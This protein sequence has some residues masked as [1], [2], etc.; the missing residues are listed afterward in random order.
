MDLNTVAVLGDSL[1]TSYRDWMA[2]GS[3]RWLSTSEAARRL[4]IR[5][6]SLQVQFFGQRGATTTWWRS[7]AKS[8]YFRSRFKKV[9][10]CVVIL[11]TNDLVAGRSALQAAAGVIELADLLHKE[12]GVQRVVVL[13]VLPRTEKLGTETVSSFE[14]K[15]LETNRLL[16]EMCDV[17]PYLSF[18]R[19]RGFYAVGMEPWT[20]DGIHA[21]SP[22]GRRLTTRSI[23]RAILSATSYTQHMA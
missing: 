20:R 21:N 8:A 9:L 5:N 4:G 18:Q 19:Q 11:S 13:S 2:G 15:M 6:A 17:E 14:C 7:H 12:H 10:V 1:V 22:R 23:R 16:K 3:R